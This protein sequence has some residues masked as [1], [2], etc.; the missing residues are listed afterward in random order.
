MF[1]L[2]FL[3]NLAIA[4]G[5]IPLAMLAWDACRGQLGANAVN[6]ALHITGI[7]SLVF[8]VLSL[9]MTPLNRWTGRG[10]WIAFRRSLGLYGF[11]YAALHLAIY[12]VYDRAL[13]MASAFDEIVSRRFLQIGIAAVLLMVPLAVTSTN[14]MIQRLG[15]RRWKLLHRAA[16]LVAVLAVVHYYMLVKSD[17][18]Q[19][20]AFGV[21]V[22]GLLATRFVGSRRSRPKRAASTPANT[23]GAAA[24][25]S[26]SKR[27]WTGELE[28]VATFQETPDVRTFRFMAPGRGPLPFDYAPGQYLAL[29]LEI[30]GQPV[31][32]SYTIASS[33]TR[34][35]ACELTIKREPV[36]KVSRHIHD[37]LHVGDRLRVIAPAGRFVF[38]GDEAPAVLLIA[39]GVGITPLMSIVRYLTDRAWTGDVYFLNVVRTPSDIIFRDELDWLAARFPR[40]RVLTTVTRDGDA[41][42][43]Q[44]ARGRPDAAVVDRFVPNVREIPI[45]ICGPD[46]MMN[47]TRDLLIEMGVDPTRI[48]TEA[49]VSPAAAST[50]TNAIEKDPVPSNADSGVNPDTT[51]VTG[52]ASST[53][54]VSFA[55]SSVECEVTTEHTLLEAGEEA[56]VDL[57][58]DCRSGVCGQCKVRLLRGRV[59][60]DV[61]DALSA[62]EKQAGQVLA[63]QAHPLTPVEID[64]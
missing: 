27:P 7:L 6:N 3:R 46:P 40:L 54:S 4:N 5:A 31:R 26:R 22:A 48:H 39:G 23:G 58:F 47:G 38:T 62:A 16:Y 43:W 57:P 52:G 42:T 18:R 8:L 60:M 24:P 30:D 11:A 25:A 33:P 63:C 17:T 2:P 28:L 64:A 37:H 34:R 9:A 14:G 20:I 15:P 61:E 19:P 51:S 35:D 55:R 36:G 56:G 53:V 50:S 10:E 13:D 59:R 32:R 1:P 21:V 45:Y 12:V 41:T 49:F 29:Q 44:G